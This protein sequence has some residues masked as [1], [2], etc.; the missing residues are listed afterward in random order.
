MCCIARGRDE[1]KVGAGA[2][3]SPLSADGDG[4]ESR[5]RGGTRS[6][7]RALTAMRGRIGTLNTVVG[8]LQEELLRL[9]SENGNLLHSNCALAKENVGLR[10]E[11]EEHELQK[12]WRTFDVVEQH[13]RQ[14]E[15]HRAQMFSGS[16]EGAPPPS[17]SPTA[18]ADDTISEVINADAAGGP[19][20]H[21]IHCM[22]SPRSPTALL[23]MSLLPALTMGEA[24]LTNTGQLSFRLE[25]LPSMA[26]NTRAEKLPTM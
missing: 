3:L 26:P 16:E 11:L 12:T 2:P 22:A 25:R 17:P 20:I 21:S 18:I 10:R 1:E 15:R 23:G 5:A 14:L 24:A 6:I 13:Y 4:G 9:R 8:D 7:E 19:P